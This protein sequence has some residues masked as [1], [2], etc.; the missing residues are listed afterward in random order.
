MQIVKYGMNR[1]DSTVKLQKVCERILIGAYIE[2]YV[3]NYGESSCVDVFR[4]IT[5]HI[6]RKW[7]EDDECRLIRKSMIN[8]LFDMSEE[9]RKRNLD[10]QLEMSATEVGS[11]IP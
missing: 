1:N 9:G 2:K 7:Y 10:Q 8:V 5:S 3:E 4:F 11:K 6:N